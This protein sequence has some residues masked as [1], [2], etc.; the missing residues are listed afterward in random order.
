M[1]RVTNDQHFKRHQQLKQIYLQH[2]KLFTCLQPNDQLDL[3][4]YYRPHETTSI[5]ELEEHWAHAVAIDY[6][7]PNRAGKAYLQILEHAVGHHSEQNRQRCQYQRTNTGRIR[8]VG[9]MRPEP[10]IDKLVMAIKMLAE[11]Q[12][13]EQAD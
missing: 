9:A 8:V 10:D 2:P 4:V 1:P 12:A 3:Y 13:K 7:L 11:H 6:S 5:E